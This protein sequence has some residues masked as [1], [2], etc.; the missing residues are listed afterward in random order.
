MAS[1]RVAAP[2]G[3]AP[4]YGLSPSPGARVHYIRVARTEGRRRL[5]RELFV[6]LLEEIEASSA[7]WARR[8][9][10]RTP[11]I[12]GSERERLCEELR[13]ELALRLWDEIGLGK[14]PGWE[15]F[16]PGLSASPSSIPRPP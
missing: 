15:L 16:F 4:L 8:C 3:R 6:G 7:A 1:G 13:Q 5:A 11:G 9:V 10:A 2:L 12:P 14:K